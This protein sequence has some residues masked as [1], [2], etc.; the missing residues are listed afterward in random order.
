MS[1]KLPLVI[2]LLCGGCTALSHGP[3]TVTV[4]RTSLAASTEISGPLNGS[5]VSP[6]NPAIAAGH[7]CIASV[8]ANSTIS[9]EEGDSTDP[10]T[11]A[12]ACL[13]RGEELQAAAYLEQYLREQPHAHL[14]RIQLAEIYHRG[15]QATRAQLHYEYFLGYLPSPA[16]D[17]LN[18]YAVLAHTR[19]R[20]YALLRHD[21]FREAYHRAAG[22]LLLARSAQQL[23]PSLADE[24]LGQARQALEQARALRPYHPLLLARRLEMHELCHQNSTAF[25]ERLAIEHSPLPSVI[26]PALSLE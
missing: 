10:L 19:L 25:W 21:S 1:G 6:P 9:S 17:P 13:K 14:F 4:A 2:A 7:P 15:Q 22:L 20:E 24:L 3:P 12:A 26:T 11:Q 23:H 16:K 5:N 18:Q 8:S